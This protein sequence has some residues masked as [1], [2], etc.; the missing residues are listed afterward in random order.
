MSEE[1]EEKETKVYVGGN[2]IP[3]KQLEQKYAEISI[4]G[5][6]GNIKVIEILTNA[7]KPLTREDIAKKANMSTGYSRD[8]LK[9]LIKK[10]YVVEFRIG[11]ARTLY[12][13]L[14]E[15]GLELSKEITK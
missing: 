4:A 9:S 13:L 15:K 2:L 6:P 8:I 5:T 12:F 11:K 10:E 7:E 14:T 3:L 1:E